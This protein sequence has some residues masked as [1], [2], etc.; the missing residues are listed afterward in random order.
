MKIYLV[1]GAVRDELLGLPVKERD[2]VVVGA[3]PEEMLKL[4]F[5][6]VGK[7]FPVFLHPETKEEYALARTERK[8]AGGYH[9]FTFDT[10]TSVTLEED[11]QRRDI[12]I[13]AMAKTPE[14]KII[15][16][17]GGQ[18]DL[19][20]KIIRH[21]SR[22]FVED[23]VRVLRV[24]RFLARFAEWGFTVAPETLSLMKDITAKGEIDHLVPE[25]VWKEMER[26]LGEKS[27]EAFIQVLRQCGALK[28]LLPEI[29]EDAE[30]VLQN[31]KSVD[32]SIIRF[33]VLLHTL[34][35]KEV[36]NVCQR[37]KV[38]SD[39]QA[40]TKLVA[41]YHS[42]PMKTPAQILKIL[43]DCDVFRRSERFP[44]LLTALCLCNVPVMSESTTI[45]AKAYHAAQSVDVKNIIA[46]LKEPSGLD[47]K[48]AI[49][50]AREEAIR[51]SLGHF[52]LS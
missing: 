21:V 11:L 43:E 15:D 29:P 28:I 47:V 34:D 14:G 8:V 33:A 19:K 10:A 4:K 5:K 38:P 39:F 51:V 25:R 50:Q 17:Y 41:K 9:G 35:E 20:K 7:F 16:P 13:N 42:V 30:L 1:G 49:H 2:W 26:A 44:K 32:D 3:T 31:A 6:P 24:G 48:E 52:Y 37:L 18:D 36:M 22:A 12:T 46:T 23:P 40:M 45:L 27:P